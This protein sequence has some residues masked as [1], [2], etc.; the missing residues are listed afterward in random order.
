MTPIVCTCRSALGIVKAAALKARMS[1][2]SY[3]HGVGGGVVIDGKIWNGR[4]VSA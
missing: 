2:A 1:L 3:G 4:M